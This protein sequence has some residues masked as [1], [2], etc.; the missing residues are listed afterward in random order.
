MTI[1]QAVNT[2][3]YP[4]GTESSNT[5]PL[6]VDSSIRYE[7]GMTVEGVS[8]MESSLGLRR[9]LKDK[10]G[11]AEVLNRLALALVDI[12]YHLQVQF[13]LHDTK[14]TTCRKSFN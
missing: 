2:Q 5:D 9:V 1:P 12:G 8:N 6:D 13:I 7:A 14:N 3:H 4:L 11:I 10:V